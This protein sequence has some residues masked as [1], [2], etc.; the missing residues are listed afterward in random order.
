MSA[1]RTPA[2]RMGSGWLSAIGIR[3]RWG[4][5]LGAVIVGA[6]LVLAVLAP[7]VTPHDPFAQNLDNRL[8]LPFWMEGAQPGHLLG[9]DGL[10][11]DYLSRLIYGARISMLIGLL[12]VVTSGLIGT[13]LG[14]LGGFFGGRVDDAVLFAITCRLSIPV[15]LVAL[16]VV[17]L[18]GSSLTLVV[19]VLGLLLWDRFAVVAR[20]TTM[21][22]RNLDYVAAAWAAGLS[23]PAILL[24]EVLPNIA[25]H[26]AVVA[27]LEMALAILLE[28][29][30]S[31]LGLGVPPPL[32]SWGLMIAE[33]KDYMFFSPW[34]IWIPGVALFVLVFGIN[35]LGDGLRDALG[36]ADSQK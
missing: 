22:V 10:G 18:L 9:T 23:T 2:R 21:Q 24:R 8:A 16:A 29:A 3:G 13:V 1:V 20:S 5:A 11:R 33:G 31:F 30:L 25:S 34:V 26:L 4:L 14:V 12:T 32:P 35:L 15:V 36:A 7:W 6:V 19:L 28:A 17:G 27:T